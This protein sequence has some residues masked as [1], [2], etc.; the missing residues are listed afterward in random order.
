MRRGLP[1]PAA[2]AAVWLTFASVTGQPDGVVISA[3]AAG[4]LIDVAPGGDLRRA[5]ELARGGDV[6]QLQP[7][8]VYRGPFVLPAKGNSQEIVIRTAAAEGLAEGQLPPPGMRVTPRHAPALAVLEAAHDSVIQAEPGAGHYRLV[9][10]EIRPAPGAF[11]F[12]LVEL[13]SGNERSVG[14]LPHHIRIERS[15]LHGD[16]SRG[17]RRGVAMNGRSLAVVDSHLS[18]FKE[19][20]TDT[21]AICGWNGPGPFEILNNYLEGAGENIM[22]GGSDPAIRDLVPSDIRIR[23][24]HIAKPLAWRTA[25]RRGPDWAIKNLLEL[26]NARRV[27][28]EGNILERNWADAQNGFA[29]LFTVRN[30]D[31]RAPWSVIEDVTFRNNIVRS[32]TS[33]INLLGRDDNHPSG[34]ARRIRIVN[35]LFLRVGDP[36]FGTGEGDGRFLQLLEESADVVVE[37]NT[38]MQT[39]HITLAEGRAHRGFVF[40]N[41]IVRHNQYGI[42]GSGR[43]PGLDTLGRYMP[44]AVVSGNL[45]IG[46]DSSSYPRDNHFVRSID[47]VGFRNPASGDFTLLPASAYRR[48]G[49]NGRDIGADLALIEGATRGVID[50]RPAVE[51]RPVPCDDLTR[52]G[53]MAQPGCPERP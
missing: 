35:N 23:R 52:S 17:S 36:P 10:L 43:A 34:T 11:A 9:G 20:G 6:I 2:I 51:E 25:P 8:T 19:D 39:G 47:E 18:D 12:N 37:Q 32:V 53:R 4:R 16:R 13:G 28:I 7:G 15:Y 27:V 26:K 31:G 45:F 50:G 49:A 24:N 40:R 5:L 46:G 33:G 22:F 21:Q 14:A 29:I 38:I 41:N 48:R 30:Q 3:T 42:F 44:G 1:F